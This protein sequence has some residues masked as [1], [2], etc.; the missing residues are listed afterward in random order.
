[1]DE[2]LKSTVSDKRVL[3]QQIQELKRQHQHLIQESSQDNEH[4]IKQLE[5]NIRK[6]E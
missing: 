2:E 4:K 6:L 1:L 5:E 3:E